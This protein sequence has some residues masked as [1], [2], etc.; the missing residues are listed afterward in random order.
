MAFA[1]TC[2]A[3]VCTGAGAI[4][5]QPTAGAVAAFLKQRAGA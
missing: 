4:D 1:S 2:G 3:V 5:P